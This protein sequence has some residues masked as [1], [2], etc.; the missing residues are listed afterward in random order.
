MKSWPFAFFDNVKTRIFLTI[1]I[2]WFVLGLAALITGA[3]MLVRGASRLASAMGIS[4]LV[5][6][7]TLVAF[8][9]SAPELAV[10]IQAGFE[11]KPD[12]MLG[13]VIGSNITNILLILGISAF[14]LPLSV[15]PRLIKLEVPVMIAI[16]ILLLLFVLNG[17][18]VFWES[19][20][21]VILL[22]LY[23]IYL[24]RNSG[25]ST[26]EVIPKKKSSK[27]M[28]LFYA[29]AGL[30]LLVA[31][32]RWLVDSAVIFAQA[33]GVSELVIGLT[34]VSIGT[35]LP[36]IT[37]SIVAAIRRERELVISS[38]I[39][40][41]ILNILAVL[42]ITGLVLPEAIPVTN[43]LIR[44]DIMILLAVSFACIP[45]FFTGHVISRA[46]GALFLIYYIAYIVYLW[47]ASSDHQVLPAFSYTML[48]F[49]VPITFFTL[50]MIAIREWS[51]R[52]R[53]WHFINKNGN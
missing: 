7:L 50:M 48:L 11:G 33:A 32:A 15:N 30:I 52:K 37:T 28:S 49:V 46:E 22:A 39:G 36:E 35:S 4:K 38:V 6:G 16:T 10:S 27:P 40:S 44:F 1:I 26:I 12:I 24:A 21:L 9:T 14:I 43:A 17:S 51:K 45:I 2:L 53:V 23:L 31:G 29:I 34:V 5:I 47:L 41:N 19:L 20:V 25:S 13:N 42:G 8:G 18:I 3:E